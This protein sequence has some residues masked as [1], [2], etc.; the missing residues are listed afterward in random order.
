MQPAQNSVPIAPKTRVLDVA[1]IK[2]ALKAGLSDFA[3]A[4]LFGLFFAGIFTLGGI[5]MLVALTVF[6]KTWLIIPVAIGFPLIGPFAAVGLYQVSR[7]LAA[8]EKPQW[9]DVLLTVFNQKERQFSWMAFVVLFI[10]W[11]WMYQIRLL[12]A[13]FLGFKTFS[14]IAG[15]IAVLTTTTNGLLFLGIGTIIGAVLSLVL[16]SVTIIAMPLLLEHELDF[17]TAM[18]VS[19]QTV[20]KSP[21]IMLVWGA[22]IAVSILVAMVPL[23]LGLLLVLPVLGHATWHLYKRAI[24]TA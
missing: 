2:H 20:L 22:I 23:F 19:V 10:F 24:I 14:S 3:S 21:V 15:F 6:H 11:I 7:R 18:I 4:P 12:L 16:F 13:L 8:G 5:F 17:V 1:D 9:R